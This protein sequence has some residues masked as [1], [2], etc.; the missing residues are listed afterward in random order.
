MYLVCG[1]KHE[2]SPERPHRPSP[3][4]TPF[5]QRIVKSGVPKVALLANSSAS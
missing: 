4:Q 1:T 3:H 5:S 2:K